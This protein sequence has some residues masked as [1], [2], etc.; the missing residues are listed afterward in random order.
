MELKHQFQ[1]NTNN[2]LSTQ[3]PYMASEY[4]I[5]LQEI[6]NMLSPWKVLL[7]SIDWAILPHVF[8]LP[9]FTLHLSI[10]MYPEIL[11]VL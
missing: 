11:V 3:Y 6:Q 4:N 2:I 7:G 5:D 9:W 1:T 8:L 10:F